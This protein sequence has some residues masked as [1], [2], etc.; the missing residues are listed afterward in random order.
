MLE[1]LRTQSRESIAMACERI[2]VGERV[3]YLRFVEAKTCNS[4]HLPCRTAR[5]E[6]IVLDFDA[7]GRVIGIELVGPDG[8]KPCQEP[9]AREARPADESPRRGLSLVRSR[10]GRRNSRERC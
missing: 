1:F 8:Q 5:D 9:D 2:D 4:D 10:T 7:D 3:C 6:M